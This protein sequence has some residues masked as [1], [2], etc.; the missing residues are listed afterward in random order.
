MIDHQFGRCKWVDL[1]GI[2]FHLRHRLAHRCQIDHARHAREVLH[3]HSRRSELD[4]LAGVGVRIPVGEPA[5]VIGGN[6][7]AVL[8][9]EQV[10]QQDLETVRQGICTL[11]GIESEDLV[12]L[13]TH[14]EGCLGVEA[15]HTHEPSVGR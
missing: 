10:L 7:G 5:D 2:A 11:N 4:L 14:L 6:V 8:S 3:D 15:V 9:A 12:R 1:G 13:L